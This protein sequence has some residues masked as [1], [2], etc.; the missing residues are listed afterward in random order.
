MRVFI[1]YWLP[2]LLWMFLIFSASGD[3]KSTHRSSRILGPILRK[4]FPHASEETI[5]KAV[6]AI[7]KCAHLTEYSIM[8]LLLW[9]ALRK[10]VKNDS[11]PWSRR[12]AWT[13]VALVVIYAASDEIHQSYVP[14]RE[15]RVSDVLI[16]T[17]GA[18]MGLLVLWFLGFRR[19]ERRAPALREGT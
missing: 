17:L 12:L 1:K 11:R 2:V 6:N 5:H 18:A 3:T 19:A 4:I 13:V 8:A 16:D 9:R 14:N 10:P 15:G 7:R